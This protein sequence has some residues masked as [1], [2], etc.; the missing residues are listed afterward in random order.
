MRYGIAAYFSISVPL[1]KIRIIHKGNRIAAYRTA[2]KTMP[3]RA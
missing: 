2:A 1:Q 3:F